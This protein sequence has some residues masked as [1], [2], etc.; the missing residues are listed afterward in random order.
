MFEPLVQDKTRVQSESVQTILARL[1]NERVYI[2]DYQRDANQWNLRKKSLFIESLLNNLTIPAFFFCEDKNLNCEV[3]DGQQRLNTIRSF[4]NDEFSIIDDSNI[5]YIAPGAPRYVGKKYSELEDVLQNIFNDYPLTIIFMPKSIPLETKLE[6]FRRINEGGTP[7]SGQ[8]IR[9][10]YYSQSK[11]V[12][13]IRLV[14]IHDNPDK[15][16]EEVSEDE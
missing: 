9:L 10:A 12:T 13:F 6:I 2:P 15:T 8:D 14:G 16:N 1:E 7:L 4:A 11:S 5:D 3:V